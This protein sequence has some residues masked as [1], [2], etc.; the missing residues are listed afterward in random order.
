LNIRITVD[1]SF[2]LKKIFRRNYQ[3]QNEYQEYYN[4]YDL[5]SS[6]KAELCYNEGD[7]DLTHYCYC[8]VHVF[9]AF[10]VWFDITS[11]IFVTVQKNIVHHLIFY[12]DCPGG[13]NH[14]SNIFH[15][16]YVYK[17]YW[18]ESLNYLI[19]SFLSKNFLLLWIFLGFSLVA[20]FKKSA[21]TE[22][23]PDIWLS[24]IITCWYWHFWVFLKVNYLK[25]L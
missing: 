4:E 8:Q 17:R 16:K 15:I 25:W 14:W 10:A 9:Q 24:A 6:S 20:R 3:F 21:S 13:K 5:N 7:A 18:L 23:W 12:I 1:V 11:V 22:N 2:I 19:F